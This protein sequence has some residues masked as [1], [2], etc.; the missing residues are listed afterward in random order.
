MRKTCFPLILFLLGCLPVLAQSNVAAPG[1]VP[2]PLTV[3]TTAGTYAMP[4]QV[5]IAAAGR[6]EKHVAGLLKDLLA[7]AGI[8][9]TVGEAPNASIRLSLAGGNGGLAPENYELTVDASG[10]AVR[11][12]DG[13]G[14]FY[15]AQTLLQ[16]LPPRATGA[17]QVPFV[18][19]QDK[20]AFGWRGSMLDVARHFFPV[21]F[22]KK[23]IDFLA[24]YKINT[25]HWHLTDDQGWRVEIKQYPKLTQV[26]AFR[27]E[28]LIGAQQLQKEADFRY[29]G[30]PHGGFYT[31][32]QIRE[33]VQ[34]AQDRYITVVPEIE[35][36][37][38]SVSVLAAYPELACKPG[39]YETRT[40]WGVSD[41]IICP[42]EQS[43]KFFEN[44]LSEVVPLF[45]GKYVHI[46]GDEAPKKV[47]QESD[48]V[49]KLM[50]REKIDDVEKVQ[51]WFNRRIEKFL[52]SKGK[53]LVGWDEILE[54]GITPGATVMSWRGEKGGIE[55]AKH[56]NNVVMSPSSDLYLNFGQN[57]V[58]HS[59]YEPL[60]ICCYLPLQKVYNYNPL[61]KELSADQHKYILGV[62]ANLWTEYIRTPER[63]EYM[64]FPRLLALAEVAWTPAANKNYDD[65][66]RRAG[67]QLPR[68][69]AKN[70]LYRVPEP[71]G[72]DSAAI[73]REGDKAVVALSTWV[74]GAQIRY[75]LDGTMPDETADRYTQ[76][77]SLPTGRRIK[78]R[79]VTIAPNGRES[80]PAEAEIE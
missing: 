77:L 5:T 25:F 57:P 11:G 49:K 30:Q 20:P 7:A 70:I 60:N 67:Q 80:A 27:K 68:L 53:K 72:L 18:R 3:Q 2:K 42:T 54:G 35:M 39:T 73:R 23:Y 55:A 79:A 69:D 64:L 46:G 21:E 38:H 44:V 51:G 8:N 41:D 29:D 36:P 45:P 52:T 24:A 15:G 58:P 62:Q 4:A 40:L 65:F 78:V 43:I 63:A 10:V 12:G 61:P 32:D 50:K 34:Y 22:V 71:A 48:F 76:P 6:E 13:A 33:V 59:P 26:S 1:V 56:G 14:L 74:P 28:S 75:T 19:I 17:V 66:L 9:A 31:Q 47:W 37:G 16:L